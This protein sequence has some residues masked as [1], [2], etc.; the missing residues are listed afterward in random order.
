VNTCLE[1]CEHEFT[2]GGR[3]RDAYLDGQTFVPPADTI[4]RNREQLLRLESLD[5]VIV[6]ETL[7]AAP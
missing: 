5:A 1:N 6:E 2:R 7:Q 3:E 4:A